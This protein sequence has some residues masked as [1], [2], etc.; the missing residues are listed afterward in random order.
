MAGKRK[1]L[2]DAAPGSDLAEPGHSGA[3]AWLR[4]VPGK[5][6]ASVSSGRPSAVELCPHPTAPLPLGE[7]RLAGARHGEGRGDVSVPEGWA[8]PLVAGTAWSLTSF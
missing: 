6:V 2:D 5:R 3:K 1:A 4:E 8:G 7:G